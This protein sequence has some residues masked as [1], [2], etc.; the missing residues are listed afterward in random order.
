[1]ADKSAAQLLISVH[2]RFA[3]MILAGTKL[4]EL[5]RVRPSIQRGDEVVIYET[6]P[7]CAVVCLVRVGGVLAAKPDAL[8]RQCG[9]VSGVSRGDFF[10]YFCG[11][12]L[13][14][15]I[16]LEAVKPLTRP[17]ELNQ[18]RRAVPGFAPPQSYHYLRTDR[19]RDRRLAACW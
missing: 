9:H 12:P 5:R 3:D 10:Q 17:V 4:V 18:L 13:G 6:S 7:T 16:K 15:A 8:W 2:P 14:Y 1:M 11:R 19:A